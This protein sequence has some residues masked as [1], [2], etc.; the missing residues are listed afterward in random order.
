MVFHSH[1]N[2]SLSPFSFLHV[3]VSPTKTSKDAKATPDASK[4]QVI[5]LIVTL[6]STIFIQ[7]VFDLFICFILSI[8]LPCTRLSTYMHWL[9]AFSGLKD[10]KFFMHADAYVA[11]DEVHIDTD[12]QQLFNILSWQESTICRHLSISLSFVPRM[13][14][15]S[16]SLNSLKKVLW[17]Q[18]VNRRCSIDLF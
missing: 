18:N 3:K 2:V 13:C 16:L 15:Q 8:W 1:S 6:V 10:L 17:A 9:Y 5:K 14:S 7:Y 4:D 12:F 11:K